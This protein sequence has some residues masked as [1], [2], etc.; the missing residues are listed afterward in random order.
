MCRAVDGMG[1]MSTDADVDRFVELLDS[2]EGFG[3]PN[4]GSDV[5]DTQLD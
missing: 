5:D 2:I 1:T 4:V 3:P